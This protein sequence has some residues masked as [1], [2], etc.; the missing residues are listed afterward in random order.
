MQAPSIHEYVKA[1]FTLFGNF[2]YGQFGRRRFYGTRKVLN[3][4]C[5]SITNLSH[6]FRLIWLDLDLDGNRLCV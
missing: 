5:Y 2:E 4:R 6:F 3:R 1:Y